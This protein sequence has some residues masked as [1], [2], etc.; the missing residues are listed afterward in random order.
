M[1][2][3]TLQQ[4]TAAADDRV[5]TDSELA[6]IGG[7][8]VWERGTANPDVIDARGGKWTV[9]GIGWTR[10]ADGKLTSLKFG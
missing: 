2:A 1:T 6:H 7:G 10:G 3:S 8:M 9:L 4:S 5:L